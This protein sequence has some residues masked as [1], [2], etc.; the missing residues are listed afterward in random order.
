MTPTSRSRSSL[1]PVRCEDCKHLWKAARICTKKLLSKAP[2]VKR[3]GCL[4]F[5]GKAC[6]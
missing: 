3:S 5:E 1:P 4:Y 2:G 6:K